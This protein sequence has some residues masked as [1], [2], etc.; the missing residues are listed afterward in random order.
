M[1]SSSHTIKEG[2]TVKKTGQFAGLGLFLAV[3]F[4]GAMAIAASTAPATRPAAASVQKPTQPPNP[5]AEAN[6]VLIHT[7]FAEAPQ[8][9]SLWVMDARRH[10]V[11]MVRGIVRADLGVTYDAERKIPIQ[12]YQLEVRNNYGE[13]LSSK[14]VTVSMVAKSYNGVKYEGN[15]VLTFNVGDEKIFALTP[16]SAGGY[17]IH[18]FSDGLFHVVSGR[19]V[20]NGKDIGA[21]ADFEQTIQR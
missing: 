5:P 19:V 14:T 7:D 10:G 13:A 2:P 17:L 21:L 12:R 15:P 4:T 11:I 6:M 8:N 18:R 16:D 1:A 20:H 3:L 9:P